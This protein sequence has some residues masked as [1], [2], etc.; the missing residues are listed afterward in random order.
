MWARYVI[1]DRV[2]GYAEAV[3]NCTDAVVRSYVA[4]DHDYCL[5]YC[6]MSGMMIGVAC[7]RLCRGLALG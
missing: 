3:K 6:H 4:Y 7:V 5:H 1:D 2:W